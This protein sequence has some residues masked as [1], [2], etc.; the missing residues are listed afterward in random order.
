MV[1]QRE[2]LFSKLL[3]NFLEINKEVEAVIV[4]D[5]E[6]LVIAGEKRE[7]IDMEI[8]SVLSSVVSPILERIRREFAFQKFGSASFDTL[9]NR[10][11]FISVDEDITLSL[12]LNTMGSIDHVSPYA[13]LLAEKTAQILEAE[14]EDQ[15]Q[16]KIPNFEYEPIKQAADKIA[17]QIYQMRLDGG[18]YRFKFVIIGDH[19][20]GKTSIV[21]RFVEK[22]FLKDYRATIGLNIISHKFDFLGNKI[23]LTLWDIGAQSYF[24]RFRKTY[25]SGAQAG[26]IVFDLTQRSSYDN[27]KNWYDE[28]QAFVTNPKLPIVIVGNKTDL[29]DERVVNYQEGVKLTSEFGKKGIS[30]IETSALTG[31]NVEDAFNLIS[32]HYISKSKEIE[33]GRL[34]KGLY[35]DINQIIESKG[36]LELTFVSQNPYWSPGLQ[37]LMELSELGE[38]ESKTESKGE[39]TYRYTSNLTLHNYLYDTYQVNNSDGIFIIFDA[40]E[41]T[42][43]YPKWKD[44]IVDI[45]SKILENKVILIGI[46]VS[47]SVN[48]SAMMEE[49]NVND[50]L[51]KKMVSLLF[52]KIGVEYRL[53]IYDQLEVMLSSISTLMK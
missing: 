29:T 32:F 21:R 53:E 26:F 47:E 31:D 6:G 37:I 27:L 1:V 8:V 43:I 18:E 2:Q 42:N 22:R 17:N 24:K 15:I 30:Y 39:K 46:R 35:T 48:W 25:Y 13:F 33:E 12:V 14:E 49:F 10:L 5:R 7:N 36:H 19:E 52:F 28:L 3:N 9:E 41:R 51:E 45:I 4:S 20:V 40:R 38:I 50:Y 16:V 44:I 11:L 23:N 34:Q